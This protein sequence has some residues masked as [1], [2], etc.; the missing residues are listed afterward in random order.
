MAANAGSGDELVN[1]LKGDNTNIISAK[2]PL[3]QPV[4]GMLDFDVAE[5]MSKIFFGKV[6]NATEINAGSPF[7]PNITATKNI[8]SHR[9]VKS[10]DDL[11]PKLG[12]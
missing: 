1:I 12:G 4:G 10:P 8:D 9:M 11:G 7:D 2:N 5:L 3:F 6:K